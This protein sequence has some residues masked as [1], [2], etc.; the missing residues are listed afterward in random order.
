MRQFVAI[1]PAKRVFDLVVT[2]LV[3]PLW[4]PVCLIAAF[5]LRISAG[6]PVIYRSRRRVVGG[7]TETI[8]KFRTMAR[9]AEQLLNRETV[10]ITDTCF[11]NIPPEHPVYT[12][13]GRFLE[14][15]ALTELPQLL[16]VLGGTMSLVGNRPLPENVVQ[17]L[18]RN[19]PYAEDRFLVH[20]GLTGPVQL[21]GRDALSDEDRLA[22]EIDYCLLS[23][24]GY[25]WRVDALILWNTVMVALRL[26]PGYSVAQVRALLAASGDTHGAAATE[27]DRRQSALRFAAKGRQ[28]LMID[29]EEFVV[30]DFGYRGL[31]VTGRSG[32]P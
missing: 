8:A 13:V 1:P 7:R 21:I 9:N 3:M 5:A 25:R 30:S 23:K 16:Y 4:L 28:L 22:I 11:L 17:A 32:R 14:R 6:S 31:R 12:P 27:F 2:V 24:F 18:R 10:P 26:R 19:Y 20:G 15:F 29:G